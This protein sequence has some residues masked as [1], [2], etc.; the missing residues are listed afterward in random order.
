MIEIKK[1]FK[2]S[3]PALRFIGKCYGD[4]DR[5]QYGSFGA[6]WGEWFATERFA[7]LEALCAFPNEENGYVGLMRCPEGGAFEYWIGVFA[8][9]DTA[10]PPGYQYTD[11]PAGDVGTCWI[12]GREDNGELFGMDAHNLCVSKIA[13]QGREPADHS[14]FF[15]LYNCPRYTT[16]DEQGKVILDYGIYLR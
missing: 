10:V 8:P 2:S 12:Y 1:V 9:E 6:K 14:W 3:R 15:E 11:I 13:E 4:G 5:D 16:P 7:P